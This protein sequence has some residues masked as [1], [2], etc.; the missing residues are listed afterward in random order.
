[1]NI[2]TTEHAIAWRMGHADGLTGRREEATYA[3]NDD[4]GRCYRDGHRM[5][6]RELMDAT[7]N[8]SPGCLPQPKAAVLATDAELLAHAAAGT[9]AAADPMQQFAGDLER[10]IIGAHAGHP[11]AFSDPIPGK[12][13]KREKPAD[14]AQA[15]LF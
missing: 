13:A 8:T 6:R 12:K 4:H 11:S 7:S 1:M 9:P 10:Q 2:P 5:G 15:S 3:R 14:P